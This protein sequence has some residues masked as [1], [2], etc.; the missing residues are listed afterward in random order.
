MWGEPAYGIQILDVNGN[1]N[2]L[3]PC[4]ANHNAMTVSEL[5]ERFQ[6]T[7][8]VWGEPRR[9]VRK[10]RRYDHFN[11]LAPCGANLSD[12]DDHYAAVDFNSL[13]P[14]GANRRNADVVLHRRLI[15]THS[16]RVGRTLLQTSRQILLKHFNSLAPCGANL[17]W[18]SVKLFRRNFNSLAPCGANPE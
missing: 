4:G 1:F 8:P 13:A 9:V 6:L 14:C 10:R 15:S 12:Q 11:S 2:S 5:S 7:R 3:A 17:I 18:I 16:P